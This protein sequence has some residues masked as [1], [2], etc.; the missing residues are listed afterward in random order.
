MSLYDGFLFVLNNQD[1]ILAVVESF[2]NGLG[3]L[4]DSIN[5][6]AGQTNAALQR[7]TDGIAGVIQ[8]QG[9]NLMMDFATR[10]LGLG[11]IRLNIQR[12]LQFIPNTVDAQGQRELWVI[13][14][15]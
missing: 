6:P 14:A 5:T 12:V 8:N 11:D 4:A 13:L 15:A 2:V 10:Q 9:F 3:D 1:N 7:F